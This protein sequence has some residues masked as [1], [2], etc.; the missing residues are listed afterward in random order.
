[1]LTALLRTLTGANRSVHVLSPTTD[2]SCKTYDNTAKL[3][4][5]NGSAPDATAST[6]ANCP[7]AVVV[8]PLAE[9][10]PPTPTPA[11]PAPAEVL[12]VQVTLP[13]TGS[14]AAPLVRIG[15]IALMLG[16]MGLLAGGRRKRPTTDA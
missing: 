5:A 9:T 1:V 12:G 16:A 4:A 8:L 7:P 15:G 2:A 10:P 14:R 6:T 11:A 13:V 3:T